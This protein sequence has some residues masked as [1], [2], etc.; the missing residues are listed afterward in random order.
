MVYT[1]QPSAQALA[2]YLEEF[3]IKDIVISP[4]SRSAP[5]VVSFTNNPY[6]NCYTIV[7]ERSAAFFA[8][9]MAQQKNK[10]VVLVCT[11]GSAIANYYPAITE[12]YYSQIPLIVLSADRP[13]YKIDIGD[14]QTIQQHHFFNSHIG[15]QT[16]LP[17]FD[18][19]KISENQLI[20]N[21]E[22]KK[23]SELFDVLSI[24]ICKGLGTLVDR[25]LPVHFNV[26]FEEPLYNTI[27]IKY[28]FNRKSYLVSLP[29]INLFENKDKLTLDCTITQDFIRNWNKSNK[30]LI[31]IGSSPPDSISES[32]LQEWDKN[33]SVLVFC[34]NISNVP[35]ETHIE[36][37]D[38]LI[39]SFS[40]KEFLDLKPDMLVSIGGMVVSKRV[41]IFLRTY[42]PNFHY[43]I[44]LFRAYDTFFKLTAHIKSDVT[45]FFTLISSSLSLRNDSTNDYKRKYIAQK[46]SNYQKHLQIIKNSTFSDLQ[47]VADIFSIIPSQEMVQLGNSS[48][49]RYTQL[50]P[51]CNSLIFYANR[52][53]SGIDGSTS[54]AVGASVASERFTTFITGD[55][56]FFYDSNAF[57]NNYVPSDLVI[58]LINNG[59][60]G[61]FKIISSPEVKNAAYFTPYFNTPHHLTAEHLT[62]MHNCLYFK[63]ED[64]K[65]LIK[66]L[67][68]VYAN[69]NF[70]KKPQLIEIFTKN[71]SSDE[72][73]KSY[74]Q[75]I[76]R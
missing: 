48:I 7:D 22:E 35:R 55:L 19:S 65:S 25:K 5:L 47:C 62:N 4:G 53:T 44:D 21:R 11:S 6:F 15:Y 17:Y 14:G 33:D 3:E 54:T 20:D 24:D 42:S 75:D 46:S 39:T 76:I 13:P 59:G 9:G 67:T 61:I 74:F 29:D 38:R 68:E 8:L 28:F 41:K 2:F 72:V 57:W 10:A 70:S 69:R 23:V 37:I 31:L 1:T 49:V 51:K 56:S 50:V 26:P 45:S 32:I 63:V 30:I 36:H 12:S 60:G 71:T 64:E 43:H 66:T 73:L 58:I 52:G 34:E 40:D 18:L 27:N 16:T